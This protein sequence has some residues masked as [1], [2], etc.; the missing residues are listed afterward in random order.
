MSFPRR[1]LRDGDENLRVQLSLLENDINYPVM[2][3][4][5]S[6]FFYMFSRFC[7][8]ELKIVGTKEFP[9]LRSPP[10]ISHR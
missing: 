3:F 6:D 2:V 1:F 10:L 8:L 7:A 5:L 4:F 9:S